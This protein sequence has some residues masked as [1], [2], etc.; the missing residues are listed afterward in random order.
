MTPIDFFFYYATTPVVDNII[1]RPAIWRIRF[2]K[3]PVT[4]YDKHVAHS[5][6]NKCAKRRYTCKMSFHYSAQGRRRI[7]PFLEG[8]LVPGVAGR[9]CGRTKYRETLMTA[10]RKVSLEDFHRFD[11]N[12]QDQPRFI[13]R[14]LLFLLFVARDLTAAVRN[15]RARPDP[16]C[17]EGCS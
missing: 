13:S 5:G 12:V 6:K 15:T 10:I 8:S 11:W 14:A 9:P 17:L 16:L 3:C 4:F 2:G 7:P 1:K